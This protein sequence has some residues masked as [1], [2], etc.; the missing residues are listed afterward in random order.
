[1]VFPWNNWTGEWGESYGWN[2]IKKSTDSILREIQ[3]TPG[4]SPEPPSLTS[5]LSLLWAE[6]W[7]NTAALS[8]AWII[9]W[10]FIYVI[11]EK[12]KII[13]IQFW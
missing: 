5:Q 2:K 3:D 9:L 4:R 6:D 1:M 13:L 8:L 10:V 11:R 7:R 12:K